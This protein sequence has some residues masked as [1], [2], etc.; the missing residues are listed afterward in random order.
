MS[1]RSWRQ[2]GQESDH[3]NMPGIYGELMRGC[4]AYEI[5]A[6][7]ELDARVRRRGEIPCTTCRRLTLLGDLRGEPGRWT[8]AECAAPPPAPEPEPEPE[9]GAE[10]SPHHQEDEMPQMITPAVP[11]ERRTT[12]EEREERRRRVMELRGQG[13]TLRQIAMEIGCPLST[14]G[15]DL[16]RLE[17]AGK[18]TD[19][20]TAARRAA[21]EL[22][23]HILELLRAGRKQ[24][25]VSNE[26]GATRSHVYRLSLQLRAESA[27]VAE[28][29]ALRAEVE[30]LRTTLTETEAGAEDL[31]NE[32]SNLRAQLAAAE[33]EA[34]E[35]RA[36]L[37]A[38]PWR[39]A[40]EL[41]RRLA[42]ATQ[43]ERTAELLL[44]TAREQRIEVAD[45]LEAAEA[46]LEVAT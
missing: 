16:Q 12:R 40:W 46:A 37:D 41:R 11:Q 26:T 29:Q 30:R 45:E 19:D 33:Q 43:E 36:Q 8:C 22:D 13:Q 1:H 39:R 20:L 6:K 4:H 5:K 24:S 3:A 31:L 17:A 21:V 35:Q 14:V 34:E 10:E 7:A 42:Q 18:L 23:E 32:L 27:A 28:T 2:E 9:P 25:D 44:A 15:S 38:N